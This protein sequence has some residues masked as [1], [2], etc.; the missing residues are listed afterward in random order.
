MTH[1][2]DTFARLD[3]EARSDWK[4]RDVRRSEIPSQARIEQAQT[5]PAGSLCDEIPAA[6]SR[7]QQSAERV[8]S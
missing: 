4:R 8:S 6:I 1:P 5:K 2:T 3:I 7:P